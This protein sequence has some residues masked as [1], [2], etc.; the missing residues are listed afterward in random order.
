MWYL[1]TAGLLAVVA[2]VTGVQGV[3]SGQP[4]IPVLAVSIVG[5]VLGIGLYFFFKNRNFHSHR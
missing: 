5:A 4:D 2:I 3:I 1:Y